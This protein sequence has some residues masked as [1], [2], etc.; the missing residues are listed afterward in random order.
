MGCREKRNRLSICC[1]GLAFFLQ[2][3]TNSDI[4]PTSQGPQTHGESVE[5]IL[6]RH[7]VSPKLL[8]SRTSLNLAHLLFIQTRSVVSVFVGSLC[9]SA[10]YSTRF[11]DLDESIHSVI[12]ELKGSLCVNVLAFETLGI[13]PGCIIRCVALDTCSTIETHTEWVYS[14]LPWRLLGFQGAH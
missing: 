9:E 10:S 5:C 13:E 2:W 3:F 12:N 4:R 8:R 6:L 1:F 14:C 11:V 7:L